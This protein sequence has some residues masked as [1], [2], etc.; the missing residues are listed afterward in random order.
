MVD[1]YT[2]WCGWCKKMEKATFQKDYIADY[3]NT[4]YY[5]VKFDAEQKDEIEYKGEIYKYI[6]TAKRGYHELA[7]VITGGRLSY[8]TVVFLDEELNVIQ[9]I[10]GFQDVKTFEMIMSYFAD[11]HYQDTPWKKYTSNYISPNMEFVN[12]GMQAK[13]ASIKN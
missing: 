1:I 4:N 12:P 7:A 5:T 8:P 10:P 2:E 6:K 13:P 3:L 9:P 11:N